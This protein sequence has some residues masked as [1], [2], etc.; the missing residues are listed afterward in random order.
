MPGWY[1]DEDPKLTLRRWVVGRSPEGGAGAGREARHR[2]G[3]RRP[4]GRRDAELLA[5]GPAEDHARAE[6][7]GHPSRGGERLRRDEAGEP[8]RA[9][10][11]AGEEARLHPLRAGALELD[12]AE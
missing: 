10:P 8:E 3:G 11:A 4:R 7:A 5:V 9:P 12:V 1:P 6:A 2:E